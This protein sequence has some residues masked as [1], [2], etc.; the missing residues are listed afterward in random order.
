MFLKSKICLT[1]LTIYEIVAV[2]LL[3]CSRTC[4]AMFGTMFCDDHVFKYFIVCFAVPALLFL[5]LM[6]IMEIVEH[7]RR[8]HSLFYKAKHAV[9]NMASNIRDRVSESVSSGDME[10]MI[11]AALVVGLKK[12]SNRNPRARKMLNDIMDGRYGN[13]DVEYDE[14]VPYDDDDDDDDTEYT[15]YE[16]ENQNKKSRQKSQSKNNKKKK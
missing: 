1:V 6:W 9:K 7:V 16:R 2:I 14:Y 15:D 13:I 10:K 4:D 8:R 3:H 11:A 5:I 12:Y